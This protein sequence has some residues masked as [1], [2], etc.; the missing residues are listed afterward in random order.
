MTYWD[1]EIMKRPLPLLELL[2]LFQLTLTLLKL[3][4]LPLISLTMYKIKLKRED[5]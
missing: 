2:L 3:R 1:P 5:Q 4:L